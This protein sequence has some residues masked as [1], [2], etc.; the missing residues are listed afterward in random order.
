M[1]GLIFL[2]E[3]FTRIPKY[4]TIANTNQIPSLIKKNPQ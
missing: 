4:F 3:Y 2:G 1:I